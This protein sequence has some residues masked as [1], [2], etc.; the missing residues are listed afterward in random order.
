MHKHRFLLFRSRKQIPFVLLYLLFLVSFQILGDKDCSRPKLYVQ[1]SYVEGTEKQLNTDYPFKSREQWLDEIVSAVIRETRQLASDKIEIIPLEK[2]VL[3]DNIPETPM[4]DDSF[5]QTFDGEYHLNFCLGVIS[6]RDNMSGIRDNSLHPA[7]S[8]SIVIGDGAEDGVYINSLTYENPDL[9][10]AIR[11]GLFQLAGRGLDRLIEEYEKTHFNALRNPEIEPELLSP[12]GVSPELAE[13]EAKVSVITRDCRD[14]FGEGTVIKVKKETER[15]STDIKK[16]WK[17]AVPVDDYWKAK[18][19]ADGGID[20]NFMLK[21]GTDPGVEEIE[22]YTIGRGN[23]KV[24]KV[25]SIPVKGIKIE[26]R[27]DRQIVAPGEQTKI[28]VYLYKVDLKGQK[29]PLPGR[30]IN[31]IT[32]GLIDGKLSPESEA[33][34]SDNGHAN[35]IYQ[36]GMNDRN[37]KITAIYQPENYPDKVEGECEFNRGLYTVTVDL[38][39]SEPYVPDG[40]MPISAMSMHVLFDEVY[41][42]PPDPSNFLS[43]NGDIDASE[44]KGKFIKFELGKS[45]VYDNVTEQ[46]HFI[47]KPPESFGATLVMVTDPEINQANRVTSVPPAKARLSFFTDLEL[48]A[49]KWGNSIGSSAFDDNDLMLEFEVPWQDLLEGKPVTLTIPYNE[50]E[51]REERPGTWTIQFRKKY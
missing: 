40:R 20:F 11:S 25:I 46:P 37:L 12:D 17:Q 38:E 43:R 22:V 18:T 39:I 33:T 45:W 9:Y 51:G 42:L 5:Q 23:K 28:D 14:Q 35:L 15:G 30:K 7:Y 3:T 31:I 2:V 19:T 24:S 4:A 44:G 10:A 32:K 48:M 13:R 6:Q 27:P 8:A 29:D 1:V 34:T 26:I 41:I 47:K 36:A 50:Y 21:R 49:I 16:Y